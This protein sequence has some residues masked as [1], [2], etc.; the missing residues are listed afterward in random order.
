VSPQKSK[1]VTTPTEELCRNWAGP[2]FDDITKQHA[3]TVPKLEKSAKSHQVQASAFANDEV[4]WK[5]KLSP[6]AKTDEVKAKQHAETVPKLEKS[7]SHQVQASAFASDEVPWKG[8]LSPF[9]KTDEVKAAPTAETEEADYI[10]SDESSSDSSSDS[11]SSSNAASNEQ[12]TLF[13][14]ASTLFSEETKTAKGTFA[15]AVAPKRRLTSGF[16]D[17]FHLDMNDP[18]VKAGVKDALCDLMW[19]PSTPSS[20]KIAESKKNI[21]KPTV[22]ASP[23]EVMLEKLR[24]E[25]VDWHKEEEDESELAYAYDYE[26]STTDTTGSSPTRQD[27]RDRSW[28]RRSRSIKPPS[29]D[30][31]NVIKP[32]EH[33][34]K[35]TVTTSDHWKEILY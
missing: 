14:G 5:G 35:V 11:S 28:W 30:T 8:K 17:F 7:A 33:Q 26:E 1:S 2:S 10:S 32:I 22:P 4:P 34:T 18:I 31:P 3:E 6:F 27:T 12:E 20:P 25:S 21:P 23:K 9:A 16:D 15:H 29:K 13:S 24:A 19:I